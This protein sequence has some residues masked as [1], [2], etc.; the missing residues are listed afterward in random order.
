MSTSS[1][2]P[3]DMLL[4]PRSQ[5]GL[6][7]DHG[8]FS[9]MAILLA[10]AIIAGFS[11]SYYLRTLTGAPPLPFFVHVHA[12]VFTSWLV[13]FVIQTALVRHGRVDL[14]QRLG[15]A[16]AAL[17]ATMVFVGIV[18]AILAARSGYNGGP[19]QFLPDPASFLLVPFRDIS[20]FAILVAVALRNRHRPEIHKRSMLMAVIGGLLPPG[21]ARLG[22]TVGLPQIIV[23]LIACFVLSGPVYDWIRHRRVYAVYVWGGLL[24]LL[25]LPPELSPLARSHLWHHVAALLI[26]AR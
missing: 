13:L 3:A 11:R 2:A 5:G 21:A 7:T 22:L 20:I 10:C 16:G 9:A 8:F 6:K 14:H 25:T 18:T 12:A 4:S 19:V 15:V 1:S 26:S 23:A 24:T 17:A